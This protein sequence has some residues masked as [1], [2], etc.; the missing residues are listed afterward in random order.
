MSKFKPNDF[1]V[2][3]KNKFLG[4]CSSKGFCSSILRRLRLVGN[5]FRSCLQMDL[6]ENPKKGVIEL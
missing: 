1:I 3:T 2:T 5:M 6:E 4:F